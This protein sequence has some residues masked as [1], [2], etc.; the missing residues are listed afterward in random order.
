[1]QLILAIPIISLGHSLSA[2]LLVHFLTSPPPIGWSE[3]SIIAVCTV[4]SSCSEGWAG[5]CGDSSSSISLAVCVLV[6]T[7]WGGVHG[8]NI[9][10]MALLKHL[11]YL[12]NTHRLKLNHETRHGGLLRV[13]SGAPGCWPARVADWFRGEQMQYDLY[14]WIPGVSGEY[15]G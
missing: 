4:C 13:C 3:P 1:M 15:P 7:R 12:Q 11:W 2:L 14:V 9:R 5:E 8:M 6:L 10:N